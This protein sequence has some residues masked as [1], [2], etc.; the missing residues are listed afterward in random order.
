ME[1]KWIDVGTVLSP[2]IPVWPGDPAFQIKRLN[3]IEKDGFNLS[4]ASMSLHTGTHIDAPAHYIDG[5]ATVDQIAPERLAGPA[6]VFEAPGKIITAQTL[7]NL[8]ISKGDRV[9]LKT[10]NSTID[11]P[12]RPF[13]KEYA[14]LDE[15]AAHFLVQKQVNLVGIDYLS[16]GSFEGGEETHRILLGANI[17]VVEGLRLANVEPGLYDMI[18]MPLKVAAD[19]APTRALLKKRQE[20][21]LI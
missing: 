13:M 19:G 18:C 7:Q 12:S 8:D 5:G 6:K 1:D 17:I 11:W 9:I 20:G 14:H 15:S 16:I 2:G 21:N 3:T 4:Y 10:D